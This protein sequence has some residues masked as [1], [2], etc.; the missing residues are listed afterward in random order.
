MSSIAS[1]DIQETV[2]SLL[3]GRPY[4]HRQDVDASVAVVMTVEEDL[5]F[6]PATFNAVLSQRML[7]GTIVVVDC[8]GGVMQPMQM[9][10]EVI[11]SPAGPIIE[12]PEGK[13]VR[14]V[15]LGVKGATSF[16]NAVMRGIRQ[17]DLDPSVRALWL[18]HDDS[19]PADEHCL[20]SLLDAWR[21][22]PTASL[23]GAKQLDWQGE[24]LHD[25]GLYAGNHG[26][27]SLVVDGE[28]DQEQYDGRQDVFAVDLAGALVPLSTLHSTEGI[29]PWFTTYGESIDFCRRI[30]LGGGRVV[31]VPQAQI[32]HRRARF[33]GVRT[34]GGQPLDDGN[35]VDPYMAVAVSKTRYSYTDRHRSW[36][37]LLW[38]WSIVQ[39][40]WLAL[41][42]LTRK[43]PYEAC[44]T[45]AL[46]WRTL[47]RL[48]SALRARSRVRRQSRVPMKSLS[49]LQVT[50]QQIARWRDRRQAFLDQR[51]V[52]VL[53]PLAKEHLRGR[54]VRRWTFALSAAVVAF[55]WIAVLYWN[56]L[57]EVCSGAVMYSNTLLPT[58][59]KF[60]QLV[61]AATTS[62][63]YASG[64]GISAPSA[65]WLLV[66][67]CVSALTAGHVAAAVAVVFFLSAPLC[68]LSF[69]ALAGIFTRS[70]TV[71]SVTSLAW[72]A[73]AVALGLYRDADVA[74]MTVMV[75]LPA[76]FAFS[77]RAVGMYR[78]EEPKRP[79][80]SVQAAAIAALCFIP[81]V[82]AEPQLLLPLMVSFLLFLILVRSHRPALLLIPLPAAF[83]CA[84]TLVNAV[85]FASDGA[86]RQIFGSVMLP[87]STH[88]GSPAILN[89]SDVLS[90]AFG[91]VS[92]PM[93]IWG[94]LMLIM[95]AVLVLLSVVSLFLPFALRVSRMMWVVSLSGF[96]TALLSAAVAVAVDADGVVA[97]S[98]LPGV[99]FMM[100]GVLSCVCLVAGGAVQRFVSLRQSTSGAVQ[101][102]THPRVL[103]TLVH[104]ARIALVCLLL[105][106]VVTC[107]GFDW[108]GHD[109]GQVHT[110]RSGLPMVAADYL[111]QRSDHRVLALRADS[112]NHVSYTVMRTQSGDLIDSSPAQRVEMVAGRVDDASTRIAKDSAHLLSNADADAIADLSKL[113]FGGIYVVRD[114]A[115]AAQKESADQL[116]SNI[117]ASDGTQSVVSSE[118][119]TYYR[120][121]L[122]DSAKQHINDS[123][124]RT[125]A[126]SPW[127]SAW[128][129]CMGII[130]VLYCLVAA[131]RIRHRNQEAA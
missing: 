119:G 8:T 120:L 110:S 22:T 116:S 129:W 77:F 27:A 67:M 59:A 93:G 84:P 9:S 114:D 88:D 74:M 16:S 1:S 39:S 82:A 109:R 62:W 85:R 33:E 56:V 83:V 113:G 15:L 63:A 70:D 86:W 104:A 97:G 2:T 79:H 66:L 90:R 68:V 57:R 121:T 7:P 53:G 94:T 127:R 126:S 4:S 98:V 89:L 3:N 49:T 130:I 125:A 131:P 28:P 60:T 38:L 73:L 6:F 47:W 101:L 13:T 118:Q 107:M 91:I 32:A 124:S 123:G 111:E 24:T 10:F 117:S 20:E 55:A 17:I 80:H 105:A 31:V 87:N 115:N 122:Q 43:Q 25:V 92:M 71:R 103:P 51:D 19:R 96:V 36:W 35:R 45:L 12:M 75:F 30:C 64:T 5:R 69:W 42:C 72:F 78:T 37:P 29:D 46:P 48:P 23:L 99:S 76:A 18:L 61:E 50:R 81:V 21:N 44:C 41:L 40:L 100:M 34:K 54:L 128:L 11:P 106:T 65:P 26:V 95:L 108:F 112:A 14:V 102:E 52:V 58:S